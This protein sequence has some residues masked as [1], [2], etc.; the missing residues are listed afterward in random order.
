M[1]QALETREP[2]GTFLLSPTSYAIHLAVLFEHLLLGRQ[3]TTQNFVFPGADLKKLSRTRP[4]RGLGEP[5]HFL[6]NE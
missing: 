3:V 1:P 5:G 4:T 6:R 2:A